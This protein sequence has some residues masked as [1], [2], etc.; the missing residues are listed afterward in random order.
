VTPATRA[1]A[2]AEKAFLDT[3]VLGIDRTE[4]ADQ[5]VTMA[6]ETGDP[7]V[8]ARA[9]SAR[10]R[11][12]GRDAVAAAPF[13]AE[14]IR[15]ARDA[16]HGWIL[17]QVLARQATLAI[18]STGDPELARTAAGE[19][20]AIADMIGNG[21]DSRQCRWCLGM[22]DWFQG[23]LAEAVN[24]FADLAEE[25][26]AQRDLVWWA[27][28][29]AGVSYVLTYQ[30]DAA[31]ARAAAV[32]LVESGAE[33]AEYYE[34]FGLAGLSLAAAAEGDAATAYR[35][36]ELGWRQPGMRRETVAL[37]LV[38][39][40]TLQV[41]DVIAARRLADE[42]VSTMAGWHRV[43]ALNVRARVAIA[44]GRQDLAERDAHDAL[45]CA[46]TVQVRHCV[47]DILECLAALSGDSGSYQ[48]AVRLFGAADALRQQTTEVRFG[49]FQSDYDASCAAAR[50]ALDIYAFHA[51]WAEGAAL[52]TEEAIAYA[53]RGRGERRRPSTGWASLTPTELDVVRLV[54]EGLANKDIATRL[55]ISPRTVQTHLTHVYTKLGLTSRVQLAQETARRG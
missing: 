3:I 10:A 17:S 11:G 23:N 26:A 54:S 46:A 28:C 52:S 55:F 47:P 43:M 35:Q 53:Q 4:L 34:A 6:R 18:M 44:E 13:I 29:L 51:A 12:S 9:L 41:G 25:S 14:A 24:Q 1:W 45:A 32:E 19:G 40:T 7:V 20:L 30:G 8:V 2:M 48:E 22:A 5:A 21:Y 16:G 42:A 39:L 15:L 37:T 49:F 50:D 27:I 38:A 31:G 36:I 33:I